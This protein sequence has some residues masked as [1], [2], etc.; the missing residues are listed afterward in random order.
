MSISENALCSPPS[1]TK[2][3]KGCPLHRLQPGTL[4]QTERTMTQQRE[5]GPNWGQSLAPLVFPGPVSPRLALMLYYYL[6]SL[7]DVLTRG[8]MFSFHTGSCK[9]RSWS[10]PKQI[11]SFQ[12]LTKSPMLDKRTPGGLGHPVLSSLP[13][14]L[15]QAPL[16]SS[17]ED[18]NSPPVSRQHLAHSVMSSIRSYWHTHAHTNLISIMAMTCARPSTDW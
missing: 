5:G 4:N 3:S 12:L 9:L 17:T 7:H 15:P 18:K 8:L 13:G 11:L 6:E 10:W 1:I 2:R 14:V 16:S